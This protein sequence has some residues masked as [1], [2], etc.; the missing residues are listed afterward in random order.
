MK[1]VHTN[2]ISKDW[3][4]LAEFY[5]EVFDCRFVPPE[6]N[7][8][9]EWLGQG[10]GVPG[11]ELQGAHLLLPG[12]GE[13]GPTLEI[14]QYKNVVERSDQLPNAL[15]FGHIS[16][17]VSD[18]KKVLDA[19]CAKGGSGFGQITTREIEGVGLL[20]FVYARDPEGNFIE[21]QHWEK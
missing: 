3:K 2:I 7:Q 1:Y 21:I 9:G 5:I 11:A 10:T 12:Y 13:D 14:Y 17:E 8:A 16:F 15:G 6:R 4:M 20:T 18:V 19:V